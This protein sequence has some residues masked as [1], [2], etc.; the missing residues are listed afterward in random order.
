MKKIFFT[1]AILGFLFGCGGSTPPV[2]ES[3]PAAELQTTLGG[4]SGVCADIA[5]KDARDQLAEVFVLREGGDAA[6]ADDAY[7]R[8]RDSYEISLAVYEKNTS[9]LQ[10]LSGIVED[11][12][13]RLEG[14]R[15]EGEELLPNEFSTAETT[16]NQY[17]AT[18]QEKIDECDVLEAQYDVEQ[19]DAEL[20][21]L[22]DLLARAVPVETAPASETYIVKKGDSLWKIAI[23]KYSDPYFWP[24]IYWANSSSIKDPDLI[25]PDQEFLIDRA[26]SDSDKNNAVNTAKTRGPW[27]LYDGK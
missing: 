25:Y 9:D 15:S 13:S 26:Y 21:L 5:F 20:N 8:A 2:E 27:S 11:Q 16:V 22:E 14:L 19:A 12:K 24:L 4:Y 17:H 23:A 1:I 10:S 3:D 18:A 7:N 6:G